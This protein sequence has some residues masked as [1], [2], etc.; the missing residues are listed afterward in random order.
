MTRII[1]LAAMLTPL[2]ACALG[3][4]STGDWTC[5]GYVSS[6]SQSQSIGGGSFSEEV[7]IN[8]S[9]VDWFCDETIALSGNP[10]SKLEAKQKLD[11]CHIDGEAWDLNELYFEVQDDGTLAG[12]FNVDRNQIKMLGD[13]TCQ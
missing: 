4:A 13:F 11:G 9:S 3:G 2:T 6:V 12:E 10:D 8:A 5:S 1:T 7:S